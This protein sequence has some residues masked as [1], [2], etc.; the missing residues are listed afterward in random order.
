MSRIKNNVVFFIKQNKKLAKAANFV[1]PPTLYDELSTT[2]R[3]VTETS[4]IEFSLPSKRNNITLELQ[5]IEINTS[6]RA[7]TV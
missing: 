6:S 3:K 4:V 5:N 7:R 1:N 2:L